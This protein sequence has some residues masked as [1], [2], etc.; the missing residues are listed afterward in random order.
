MSDITFNVRFLF[1]SLSVII[2]TLSCKNNQGELAPVIDEIGHVGIYASE[3]NL[4]TLLELVQVKYPL[5]DSHLI[6]D[7]FSGDI[8]YESKWN[9]TPIDDE[10]FIKNHRLVIT[11]ESVNFPNKYDTSFIIN[12][13]HINIYKDPFGMGQMIIEIE[14]FDETA[15]NSM[16]TMLL[17]NKIIQYC[18]ES[19]PFSSNEYSKNLQKQVENQFGVQLEIPSNFKVF[20]K[21]SNFIWISSLKPNGGYMSLCIENIP[22]EKLPKTLED[23]ILERNESSKIHFF[24][25][26]GTTMAV[27]DLGN[28]KSKLIPSLKQNNCSLGF[29]GWFTELGTT[30]RGPFERRYFV[31]NSRVIAI[32][33]FAQGGTDFAND[34]RLL[35]KIVQSARII[36]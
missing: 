26:E 22:Q 31:K 36:R 24:N 21:D 13:K 6:I 9:F 16:S 4:N 17:L 19:I 12:D 14:D 33:W 29:R 15:I 23:A 11:D 3:K 18:D 1:V 32:E 20:K 5:L 2:A 25:D 34:A 28:Y 10:D 35:R 8:R 7:D 27:S 30:R